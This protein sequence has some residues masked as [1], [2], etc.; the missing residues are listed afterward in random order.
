MFDWGGSLPVEQDLLNIIDDSEHE[1]Q[2]FSE[3]LTDERIELVRTSLNTLQVNIGKLCNQACHHCHVDAGPNR[4]ELMTWASMTRILEFMKMSEV[5][6]VDITGGAPELNPSFRRFVK[7]IRELGRDVMVRCN[8]TV[9]FEPSQDDLPTFY[10]ENECELVCS[11]PCYLEENVDGQ[12]GKGVFQKSIDALRIL[13]EQG[14]GRPGSGLELHLV[15]N[16]VGASLPPPQEELTADY[17]KELLNRFGIVFNQLYSIT[18]MPI[19]RF[20]GFLKRR[21]EYDGYMRLLEE[22]FNLQTLPHIMCRSLVSVDWEGHL[23]DCD[24]NQM[25]DMHIGGASKKIWD[26]TPKQLTMKRIQT[27]DHCYGC[28]A[29]AGSSCGGELV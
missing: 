25:L 8:L 20:A 4:T 5:Q 1:I 24:F 9:I 7:E 17:R 19:N 29:G 22:N 18:N 28:T 23:F 11:L 2:S 16:P 6:L 3:R 15:Y 14:Y 27:G 12:R 10:R 13:N 21:G 26:Y